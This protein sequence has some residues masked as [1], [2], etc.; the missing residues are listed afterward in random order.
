MVW[1]FVLP[2]A[3]LLLAALFIKI[4]VKTW[5]SDDKF[6]SSEC[7][8]CGYEMHRTKR[9]SW[10][11]FVSHFV[12]IRTYR[13]GT[14]RKDSVRLKPLYKEPVLPNRVPES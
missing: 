10:W 1:Y 11:R 5:R 14:C 7:T 2:A 9:S 8:T 4:K 6:V 3:S 12:E 13:C